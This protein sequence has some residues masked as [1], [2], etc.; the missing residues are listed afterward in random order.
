MDATEILGL[1][2]GLGTSISSLPQLIKIFKE[3]K[4][5]NVSVIM[6]FVLV[7][8]GILWTVYGFLKG[9][10]PIILTNCIAVI[11]NTITAILRVKYSGLKEK[12]D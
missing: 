12:K 3:K 4:A 7:V 5:E 1:V 2:A 11:I 8:A 9:D 10:L 6:L